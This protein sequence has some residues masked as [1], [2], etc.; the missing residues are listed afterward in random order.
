[1]RKCGGAGVQNLPGESMDFFDVIDH[2]Y[3]VRKFDPRPV[4]EDIIDRI[5][6]A[7]RR[8]PT[9]V[10]RQP[11]RMLVLNNARDMEKLGYCTKFT[12]GAPCAIVL[13][14]DETEAWVR[15]Y[16]NDNSGIV[17]AAIAGTFIMLSITAL[18]LGS[19]WVGHFDPVAM[20]SQFNLPAGTKPVAVLPFGHIAEDARPSGLHDKRVPLIDLVRF[21]KF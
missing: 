13:C 14:A 20:I 10:N 1:M 18:G 11:Q 4:D 2:R 19:C 8:A 7:A 9:A 15:P 16:D 12:F 21:H 5:L 17:D 6:C 3:S